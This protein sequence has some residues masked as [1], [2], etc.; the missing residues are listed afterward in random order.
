METVTDGI[1]KI[2]HRA[3]V[4]ENSSV[5]K[6]LRKEDRYDQKKVSLTPWSSSLFKTHYLLPH[7]I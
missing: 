6:L 2:Y 1:F 7:L 4:Y 3:R 5:L